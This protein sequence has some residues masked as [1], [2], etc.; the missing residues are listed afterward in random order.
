VDHRR[1]R[2]ELGERVQGAGVG[3]GL[4]H[5]VAVLGPERPR[6]PSVA[7]RAYVGEHLVAFHD[8]PEPHPPA[9]H[10]LAALVVP[11]HVAQQWRE[12]VAGEDE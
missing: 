8:L 6:E 7:E 10:L 4:L 5:E 3:G 9:E 11:V 2:V 12:A 1:V